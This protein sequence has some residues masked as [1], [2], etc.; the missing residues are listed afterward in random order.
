MWAVGALTLLGALSIAWVAHDLRK[1]DCEAEATSE[2]SAGGLALLLFAYA[3]VLPALGTLV[4]SLRQ[5]GRPWRWFLA[6]IIVY[7]VGLLVV[8]VTEGARPD[9]G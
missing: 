7:V 6:T 1:L 4:E 3:G 8:V 5:G 2:C 9:P